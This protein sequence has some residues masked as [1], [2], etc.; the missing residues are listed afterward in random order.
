MYRQGI[1]LQFSAP[2]KLLF[3]DSIKSP[4][5]CFSSGSLIK[6][7][8]GRHPSWGLVLVF[9]QWGRLPSLVDSRA[10]RISDCKA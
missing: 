3:I 4:L 2:N 9:W 1:V 5:T 8:F 7:R 10:C 6:P